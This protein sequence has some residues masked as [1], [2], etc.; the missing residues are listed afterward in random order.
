MATIRQIIEAA[1]TSITD[2]PAFLWGIPHD[3]NE[4]LDD[5]SEDTF[6]L[7]LPV[8]AMKPDGV[9]IKYNQIP[10]DYM[11]SMSV[12]KKTHFADAYQNDRALVLEEMR[13]L[14]QEII[15][16]VYVALTGQTNAALIDYWISEPEKFTLLDSKNHPQDAYFNNFDLNLDGVQLTMKINMIEKAPVCIEG[17]GRIT[18]TV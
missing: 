8:E 16:R 18:I 4:R 3:F 17:V 2:T 10:F 13:T 6:V 9:S 15:G 1:V 5:Y 14:C 11:V 7:M 12:M